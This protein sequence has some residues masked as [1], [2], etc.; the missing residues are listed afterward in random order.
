MPGSAGQVRPRDFY[1]LDWVTSRAI[2]GGQ[3]TPRPANWHELFLLRASTRVLGLKWRSEIENQKLIGRHSSTERTRDYRSEL[4][5]LVKKRYC[6]LKLPNMPKPAS[7][8]QL[9][10]NKWQHEIGLQTSPFVTRGPR[11]T[12]LAF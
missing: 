9:S 12:N 5:S 11:A 10:G 4:V 6:F 7:G 2:L 1:K 8:S 3:R